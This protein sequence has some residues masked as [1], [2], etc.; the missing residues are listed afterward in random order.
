MAALR[1]VRRLTKLRPALRAVRPTVGVVRCRGFAVGNKLA[2]SSSATT[3]LAQRL[4]AAISY[5]AEVQQDDVQVG[6]VPQDLVEFL[7]EGEWEIKDTPANDEVF[8]TRRFGDESIR[9]M[10]S[11]ADL[12]SISDEDEPEGMDDE[13]PARGDEPALRVSVAITKSTHPGALHA[14]LYCAD[15]AFDVANVAY[16]KDA[17]IA[18][19]LSITSDCERRTLWTGPLF[20]S[21]DPALKEA[22]EAYLRERGV[23]GALAGFVPRYALWARNGEWQNGLESGRGDSEYLEW[24]HGVE[25][26]VKA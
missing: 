23:D 13:S 1:T 5:E 14:D 8:L 22:F 15:G 17:R 25:G 18:T 16:Y 7:Q 24:L 3:L 2:S 4:R 12:Q 19:E 9:F 21:L 20:E 6:A 10:F 26:F 11:I